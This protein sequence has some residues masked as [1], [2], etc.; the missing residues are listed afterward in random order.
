ML[1]LSPANFGGAGAGEVDQ[2]YQVGNLGK[3]SIHFIS[4]G[5]C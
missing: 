2:V 1:I 3:K 4:F 5:F